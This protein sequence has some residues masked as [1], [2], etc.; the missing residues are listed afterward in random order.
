MKLRYSSGRVSGKCILMIFLLVLFYSQPWMS[1]EEQVR[2]PHPE[3]SS[4]SQAAK[5]PGC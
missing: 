4:G 2:R 3:G 1:K 5:H